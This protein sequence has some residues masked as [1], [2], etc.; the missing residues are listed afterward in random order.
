MDAGLR[1]VLEGERLWHVAAGDALTLLRTLP[2]DS[3][4]ACVTSP[5]YFRLRSYLPAEHPDKPLELGHEET[6][7]AY[8]TGLTNV[9]REVRR[10]L[11]PSGTCWINLGDSYSSAPGGRPGATTQRLGR[12]FTATG[13]GGRV[14]GLKHKDLIGAPWA[15]AFALRADGWW[16]RGDVILERTNVQPESVRDRPTRAHEYLFLLSK[17]STYFYDPV[18]VMEPVT[19]RAHPRGRGLN[20]KARTAPGRVRANASFATAVTGIVTQRNRRSVWHMTSRPLREEHYAAFTPELPALCIQAGTSERG[21]CPSCGS[22]W[23][24]QVRRRRLVDG[25]PVEDLGSFRTGG[26]DRPSA[27]QGI[28]HMRITSE[29][30]TLGWRPTCACP[31]APPV[32]SLVL[33]PFAGAGTTLLA[34]RR[35]RRRALG[36]ELNPDYVTMATRRIER[37]APLLEP[38]TPA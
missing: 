18:A 34:A 20:P 15:V 30:E 21:C 8:V 37:D 36:L 33:D 9:F 5:P 28:S 24:R 6:I 12:R 10:V 7:A 29:V 11:H 16:L 4:H 38:R 26:L 17:R 32:P 23:E 31:A 22:P 19:G 2:S 14:P 3:V 25:N 1:A 27:A 35:L 13:S